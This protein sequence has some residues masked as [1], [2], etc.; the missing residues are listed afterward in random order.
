MKYHTLT[1]N[2]KND[3]CIPAVEKGGAYE[4][5]C[6]CG[7]VIKVCENPCGQVLVCEVY[8]EDFWIRG[9]KVLGDF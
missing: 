1:D 2:T 4:I 5:H 9:V 6:E 7:A 8:E 3:C